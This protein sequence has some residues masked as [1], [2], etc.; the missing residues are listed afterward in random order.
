MTQDPEAGGYVIQHFRDV[1]ADD[2]LVPAAAAWLGKMLGR[3]PRDMRGDRCSGSGFARRLRIRHCRCIIIGRLW[4]IDLLE[5]QPQLRDV[6][7]FGAAA[8]LDA[9][10]PGQTVLQLFDRQ[11]LSFDGLLCRSQFGPLQFHDLSHLPQHF[12]QE[13]RVCGETIKVE[14]HAVDYSASHIS[15]L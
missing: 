6:H 13:D 12:L 10:K 9:Q 15:R 7:L 5:H 3:L 1:F 11:A 14:P 4:G 2:G 8:E